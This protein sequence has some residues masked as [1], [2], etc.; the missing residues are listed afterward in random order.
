MEKRWVVYEQD[1]RLQDY[2]AKSLQINP[3]IAKILINRGIKTVEGINDFLT[4]SIN[5]LYDP[6]LLPDMKEA[7]ER[8]GRAISSM[9]LMVLLQHPS[10]I[11]FLRRWA[12][13]SHIISHTD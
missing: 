7:V 4:S 12:M 11:S 10:C 6:F 9:M 1:F 5:N 3:L 2:I 8:I 13:M